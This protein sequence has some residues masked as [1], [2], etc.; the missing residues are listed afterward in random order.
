[1]RVLVVNNMAPFVWGGAEELAAHLQR[2]LLAEGHEAEV[3]RIPFRW[4]PAEVVASQML[5]VRAL[6]LWNVDRVIA[7]KFPAYLIRHP[8]KTVWLLHQFR[9]VYDLFDAGHSH[10]GADQVGDQIRTLVRGGDS[11]GL[12]ESRLLFS[13]SEITKRRLKKYNNLDAEVLLPPLNDPELFVGGAQDGYVFAGGRI[14]RMKRQ[15]VFIR[16]MALTSVRCRLVVAGPPDSDADA[17]EV[18]RLVEELDLADR[19]TLDLRFLDRTEVAGYVNGASACAYAPFDED[20]LGYVAMEAAA[21][22]KPILTLSDSGGVLGLVRNGV[23]GW[24]CDPDAGS[25]AGAIEDACA[26]SGDVVER[27]RAARDLWCSMG[28]SWPATLARLLA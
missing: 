25:V 10:V 5:L 2:N 18:K 1:M 15:H 12:S 19:V 13:N 7:L 23:T 17:D 27:G 4:A 28:I 9:Q 8:N 26:G 21:A 3:L 20:S 24:V 14:N 11:E 6:E 16:A 22:A